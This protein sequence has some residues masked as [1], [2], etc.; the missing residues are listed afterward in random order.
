[1]R[2]RAPI[3]LSALVLLALPGRAAAQL[4]TSVGAGVRLVFPTGD[5]DDIAQSGWGLAG[6]GEVRLLEFLAATGEV[7]YTHLDGEERDGGD[8][9]DLDM[10]GVAVGARLYFPLWYL[11]AETG[12]FS[13]IDEGGFLPG[14]GIRIGVLDVGARYKATGENWIELR[15]A[16][17]F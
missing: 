14:A 15:G 2:V 12:Y 7:S 9:E 11:S 13:E 8:L 17:V 1:M 16:V 10:L 6:T 3:L 4:A 5:L